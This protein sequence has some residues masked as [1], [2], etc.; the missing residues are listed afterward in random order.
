MYFNNNF[1]LFLTSCA[2]PLTNEEIVKQHEICVKAGMKTSIIRILG[3]G[4]IKRIE[5]L[6]EDFKGDKRGN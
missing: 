4:C 3:S 6:P 1:Y 2:K 5:C